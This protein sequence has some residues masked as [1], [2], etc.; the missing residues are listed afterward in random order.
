MQGAVEKRK[1]TLA[2]KA[3]AKSSGLADP[4]KDNGGTPQPGTRVPLP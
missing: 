1:S 3:E 4:G 2:K